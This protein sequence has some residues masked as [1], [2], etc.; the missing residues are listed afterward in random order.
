M[1]TANSGGVSNR[2]V[3]EALFVERADGSVNEVTYPDPERVPEPEEETEPERDE[4]PENATRTPR[5]RT[6]TPRKRE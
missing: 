3:P 6:R 2:G 5:T 1:P 4:S